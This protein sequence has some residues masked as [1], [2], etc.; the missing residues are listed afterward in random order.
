MEVKT[1]G[2]N[3]KTQEKNGVA[4]INQPEDKLF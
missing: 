2:L 1:M 3:H 4:L